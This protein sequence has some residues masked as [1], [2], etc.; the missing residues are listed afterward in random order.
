MREDA[1]LRAA[2]RAAACR[3]AGRRRRPSAPRRRARERERRSAAAAASRRRS[4]RRRSARSRSRSA[5][6]RARSTSSTLHAPRRRS[7]GRCR[8]R[9][10]SRSSSS[11]PAK[12]RRG[13]ALA[14]A[15]RLHREL[16]ARHS[17]GCSASRFAS[18]ARIASACCSV[19]PMSSRPFSRQC[20]RNGSTSKRERQRAVG[21]GHRLPLEVDRQPEA[22]KRLR[23]VRTAGRPRA[24]GS[25]IGSSPFL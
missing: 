3:T 24:S 6:R 22:G 8:R 10:G 25:T 11:T 2:A 23:V 14:L 20:L 7:R 16:S 4:R 15:P 17:H 13:A 21:R 19:R 1:L 12:Q 5:G 9:A 18:N